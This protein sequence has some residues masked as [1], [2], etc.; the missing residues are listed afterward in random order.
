MSAAPV[1]KAAEAPVP[2]A[3]EVPAPQPATREPLPPARAA[4]SPS[5]VAPAE[6]AVPVVTPVQA[7]GPRTPEVPAPLPPAREPLPPAREPLLPAHVAAAP[8]PPPPAQVPPL[9]RRAP[10]YDAAALGI[11]FALGFVGGWQGWENW[12]APAAAPEVLPE[13]TTPAAVASAPP[14]EPTPALT[15]HDVQVNA[16]PWAWIQIDGRPVGV[17][18]LVHRDLASGEHEFEATFPDGRQQRRTVAI[19]PDSR[20]VSFQD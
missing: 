7:P 15:Y 2:R 9:R 17:T 11:G 3:P 18:P 16:R 8:R 13:A 14:A 12:E 4:A 5:V 19:G 10:W 20:F 1:V 6:P